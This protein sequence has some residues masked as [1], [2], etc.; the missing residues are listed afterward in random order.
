MSRIRLASAVGAVLVL[1][2]VSVAVA[3]AG[4]KASAARTAT[5]ATSVRVTMKEFKFILSR[6]RVPHG[7]VTFNLVNKGALAH[8]FKIAGK[9]SALIQPGKTGKL[10]VTLRKGLS[11]Y[12]CTVPGHAVAGMKGNL[13]V[14]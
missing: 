6:S 12:L 3:L 2:L 5:A 13:R 7:R 1:A 14:T 4:S 9:K 10:T 8:D 11:H